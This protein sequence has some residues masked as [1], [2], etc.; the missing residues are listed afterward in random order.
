MV[1]GCDFSRDAHLNRTMI[2]I[3]QLLREAM[4]LDPASIG[5]SLIH[6]SVR[7]RMKVL[8]LKEVEAYKKLLATSSA[9][10]SELVE[11]VVVTE[12][13]F[14]RHRETF[15]VLVRL[16]REQWL[17]AHPTAPL[18]LLSLPC[19]SGEEPYSIAMA[20]QDSGLPAGRFQIDAAD[21]SA[22]ALEKARQ[23][24]YR[25]N[26][27]RGED[28][29]FRDRHFMSGKEGYALRPSL[30]HGV[31]FY[32]GNLLTDEFLLDKGTYDCIFCRNLLIYFDR[33]TQQRALKKLQRLLAPEGVLFVGPAELPLALDHGYVSA[34]I[35]MAFACRKAPVPT[36]LTGVRQVR[37]VR[38][39]IPP[40]AAI[41]NCGTVN[42]E[43][44]PHFTVQTP[45]PLG[46]S[47]L[48]PKPE[49]SRGDGQIRSKQRSMPLLLATKAVESGNRVQPCAS[50]PKDQN[51]LR[52]G[53]LEVAG[54]TLASARQFAD[55]GRLKEAA[56]VCERHLR[57]Y[58]ASA[59]AYYLLG[60]VLEAQSSPYAIDCY[61]KA[62]YL[63]PDHYE[64]LLQMAVRSRRDGDAVRADR[65]KRR[66]R[67]SIES[68]SGS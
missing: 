12:S 62:L 63:Q 9:E 31:N 42:L 37:A 34:G 4:G 57:D 26:S 3:E 17:P 67:Q 51:V 46:I 14:F 28:L 43:P 11:S 65:F 60:L 1:E 40:V 48:T 54:A 19:S 13:W 53:A 41:A 24:V 32:P 55:A 56:E 18:R 44:M 64:T 6:R 52:G 21:I 45:A 66:A 39:S 49:A 47:A 68:A 35:P 5:S 2:Q 15:E 30:R 7:L 33:P 25:R 16:V 8:N 10:W 22:R 61:R 36:E 38:A 58:G 50:L 23:G 59:N 29:S 20:L 27:F